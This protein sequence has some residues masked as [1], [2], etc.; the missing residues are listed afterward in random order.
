MIVLAKADIFICTCLIFFVYNQEISGVYRYIYIHICVCGVCVCVFIPVSQSLRNKICRKFVRICKVA[1]NIHNVCN[2]FVQ[3]YFNMSLI[4]LIE[5]TLKRSKRTG[6]TPLWFPK[7]SSPDKRLGSAGIEHGGLV[8]FPIA[9]AK[10][11]KFQIPLKFDMTFDL[12]FLSSWL[13][14][15]LQ[16]FGLL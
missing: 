16:L 2:E 1:L 3:A 8:S 13:Y 4:L 12:V 6:S 7:L 11:N 9:C 5:L 15:A 10:R 14:N